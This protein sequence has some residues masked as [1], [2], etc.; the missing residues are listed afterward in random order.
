MIKTGKCKVC[1]K[2]VTLVID[3]SYSELG[4]PYKLERLATCDR[5]VTL[6]C[7][8]RKLNEALEKVAAMLIIVGN[9]KEEREALIGKAEKILK[10]YLKLICEREEAKQEVE[11]DESILDSFCLKPDKLDDLIKHLWKTVREA[12]R[13]QQLELINNV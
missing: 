9:K 8:Q 2:L 3:D 7:R 11:W 12:V 5:C 1:G 4:D 10:L 13:V 6:H